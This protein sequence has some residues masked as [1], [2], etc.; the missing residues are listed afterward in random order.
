M[1]DFTSLSFHKVA[2]IGGLAIAAIVPNML[3]SNLVEEREQRQSGVRAGVHAQLGPGA[4]RARP[5]LVIPYQAGERPPH[6][7]ADRGGQAGSCGDAQSAGAP[8][9]PVQRDGLRRNARH[10][11]RVR[12]ARRSAAARVRDRQGRTLHLE[13][14]GGRIRDKDAAHRAQLIRQH[15]GRRHADRMGAVPRSVA[16]GAACKGA[17]M[18]LAKAPL[19]LASEGDPRVSSR[20]ASAC[21][22]PGQFAVVHAAKEMSAVFR[23]SWPSPSFSGDVL[24]LNSTVSADGFEAKWQ[25]TEFGSPR[26]TTASAVPSRRCGIRRASASISSRRRRSTA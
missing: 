12:R 8:A 25:T 26:I 11:G 21:A 17:D 3:I 9:R 2:L 15:H 4:D 7:R 23:S 24:P 13:R 22:A 18:V 6:L 10:A 14:S 5:V 19:P 1:P 20:D 16:P